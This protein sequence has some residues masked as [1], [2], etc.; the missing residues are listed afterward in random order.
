[1]A[2]KCARNYLYYK[3]DPRREIVY[4]DQERKAQ[5]IHRKESEGTRRLERN[6]LRW[7]L[8]CIAGLLVILFYC[9]FTLIS[10]LLYPEPVS[11]ATYYL[12]D[13]GNWAHSPTG[14]FFYNAGC[15]LTGAALFAFYFGLSKWY[16]Y[17]ERWRFILLQ[18]TQVLGLMSAIALVM[19]GIYSEDSGRL[20]GLWSSVFFTINFFVMILVNT[21]LITHPKFIK[22]I[23]LYGYT[24]TVLSLVF[25]L[26]VGGPLVEWFTVFTALAFAGFLVINM[27]KSF[28]TKKRAR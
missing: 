22:P 17:D 14:A 25:D 16:T 3:E 5:H 19:I 15:V 7:P 21:S 23:A 24:V 4:E 8:G 6:P 2:K 27:L 12:S 13:F 1:V 28:S 10:V 9:I 26:T 11:P 18:I 20:H